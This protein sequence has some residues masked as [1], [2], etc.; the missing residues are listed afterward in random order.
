[1]AGW[2]QTEPPE[3]SIYVSV[4]SRDSVYMALLLEALN[5]VYVLGVYIQGDY[6]N[7]PHKDKV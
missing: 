1:M 3:S 4:V 2:H 6:L 7:I 5:D